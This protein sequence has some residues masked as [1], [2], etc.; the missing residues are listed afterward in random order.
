MFEWCLAEP[1]SF[2]FTFI[3]EY[4]IFLLIIISVIFSLKIQ[5]CFSNN[6]AGHS[7]HSSW[8]PLPL[9]QASS[10]SHVDEAT[11]AATTTASKEN[12]G[13]GG[14]QNGTSQK[15]VTKG[16]LLPRRNLYVNSATFSVD[17]NPK[18]SVDK[19][20]DNRYEICL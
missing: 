4:S 5:L 9:G 17:R 8:N 7:L 18:I 19:C 10:S 20:S 11:T 1:K 15:T 6:A 16:S 14:G 3:L 12:G 13:G 2:F